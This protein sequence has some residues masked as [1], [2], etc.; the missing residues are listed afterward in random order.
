MVITSSTILKSPNIF[1]IGADHMFSTKSELD[2][3]EVFSYSSEKI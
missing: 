1:E 2:A 3:L